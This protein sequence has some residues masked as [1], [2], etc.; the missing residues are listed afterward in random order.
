ME[1][2]DSLPC[3]Q[4]SVTGSYPDPVKSSHTFT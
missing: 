3:L 4:K 1:P 2:G